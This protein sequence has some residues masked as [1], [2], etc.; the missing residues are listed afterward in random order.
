MNVKK[1]F[2]PLFVLIIFQANAQWSN[3]TNQFYDSLHMPVCT[4]AGD[5]LNSIIIKSYPDSGYF[6]IWEDHRISFYG[7]TQMFAQKYDKT[8]KQLWA[9]DGIP[10]SSGTNSQHFTYSSNNDFRNYSVAATDSVGG[11]YIGYADDSVSSYVWQRLMVQHIHN[12]GTTVFPGA[13]SI[14]HTSDVANQQLGHQLIADGNGGFFISYLKGGYGTMDLFVYCYKDINGT[15]QNYGGGLVNINGVEVINTGQCGNYLSVVYPQTYIIDYK[16]YSDLQKGCNVVMEF[17]QNGNLANTNNRIQTAFNWLWRVKQDMTTDNATFTKDQVRLYYEINIESGNLLCKDDVNNI[18]YNYPTSK[19]ISNG[20]MPISDWLYGAER[21]KGTT[22]QTDG[23]INANIIAV[24][25]R[26]VNN[27]VVTDWFTRVFYRPQQKFDDIPYAYKVAPYMPS[28]IFGVTPPGQNKLGSYS[29]NNND[30]LLY[31]A[32]ATYFYDF[33]LASGGNKI[34]ATGIMNNGARN[35]LL[36]QLQVQK[37]TSDS[38]VVQ[39]NTANK[40]GIRIGKERSTGFSGTDISYNN[41]Q[42]S[43]YNNCNFLFYILEICLSTL[44]IPISNFR[45]LA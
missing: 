2:T 13:G 32:G 14:L 26:D 45:E 5:Q 21:V 16:I 9:N 11:V 18:V 38:F 4:A 23:N 8:G 27:N 12:D 22:V 24:N 35:V 6:V 44:F 15:L 39:L 7:P 34:F 30:T 19:L 3:T 42:I 17:S 37:I 1:F 41:P 40:N 36:Q 33:N 28:S 29:G 20:F 31:D 10:I 43:V 25:Q